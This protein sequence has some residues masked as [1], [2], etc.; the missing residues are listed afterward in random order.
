MRLRAWAAAAVAAAALAGPWA[1]PRPPDDQEDA[2]GARHLPPF[3]RAHRLDVGPEKGWIVTELAPAPGGWTFRRAGRTEMVPA[4]RLL[5]PPAARLYVLGTDGLGRDLAS[6]LLHGI[7]RSALIAA[8]CVGLVLVLGTGVGCAAGLGGGALDALLMRGVDV[9]L[10][11]PRLLLFLV[12]ASLFRPSTAML[13]LALGLTTWTGL[14]PLVRAEARALAGG[15]A[16]LA[17]RALGASPLRVAALH[18]V[19]RMVPLLAVTAALRF[20]DTVLLESALAFLGLGSPPP[21]VSLGGMIAAGREALAE[22]WWAA[23]LPGAALAGMALAVRA[24]A[25]GILRGS[26]PPSAA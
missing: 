21:S 2:A 14:A 4:G 7:R 6:R 9:L 26:E 5:A 15:D 13:I 23:A 18:L 20:A 3:T 12:C 25:A 8:A 17:A 11:V 1:A 24:A 10:A 22:A 16:I 19:P